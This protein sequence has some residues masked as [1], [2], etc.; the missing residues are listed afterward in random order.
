MSDSGLASRL[1]GF[2]AHGRLHGRLEDFWAHARP[3]PDAFNSSL[4][5]TF[6]DEARSLTDE[7]VLAYTHTPLMA[8]Y[9]GEQFI[10]GQMHTPSSLV[11]AATRETIGNSAYGSSKLDV[12]GIGTR[13]P[14]F[15]GHVST[16][17]DIPTHVPAMSETDLAA[18]YGN[19][20]LPVQART[21]D[22]AV[23]ET[24]MSATPSIAVAGAP[25]TP[26][27]LKPI[28]EVLPAHAIDILHEKARTGSAVMFRMHP[29][30][31]SS[32]AEFPDYALYVDGKK[33]AMAAKALPAAQPAAPEQKHWVRRV[34][35]QISEN[36]SNLTPNQ[37]VGLAVAGTAIAVGGAAL[38]IK[39]RRDK[40][41]QQE[42][43]A[44][45]R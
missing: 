23:H 27:P 35:G 26:I 15:L 12:D 3:A 4:F 17:A 11:D 42:Q 25:D 5:S 34:G 20:L 30:D 44:P 24:P 6:Y 41:A 14:V 45:Q 10:I 43:D 7:D 38:Y 19:T 32:C 40:K 16:G 1:W 33:A 18:A 2:I 22:Y 37:R 8:G 13:T 31:P 29:D 36:F 21:R 28:G 9:D 39:H